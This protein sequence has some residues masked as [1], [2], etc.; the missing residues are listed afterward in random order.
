[1]SEAE[2]KQKEVKVLA[3]DV[4]CT[5]AGAGCTIIAIGASVVNSKFE[6]ED[7]GLWCCYKPT[8]ALFEWRCAKEFWMKDSNQDILKKIHALTPRQV[9]KQEQVERY[10]TELFVEFVQKWEKKEQEEG[11]MLFRCCDNSPFDAFY[12]NTF[13]RKYRPDVMQLPYN[14]LTG[15][16]DRFYD[17]HQMQRGFLIAHDPSY[18]EQYWGSDREI[19]KIWEVPPCQVE[20]DHMPNNDAQTIAHDLQAL[21][22]IGRGLIKKRIVVV[23]PN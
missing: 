17:V 8:Q 10:A 5:G 18:V 21:I 11:F 7:S 19:N 1:M 2:A 15:E 16:Y 4:E 12:I 22:Q 14:F 23:A 6:K 9:K 3:F 13:M 20:H